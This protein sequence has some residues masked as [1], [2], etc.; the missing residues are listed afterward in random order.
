MSD[1]FYDA[2]EPGKPRL[3]D[4]ALSRKKERRRWRIELG[5]KMYPHLSN[6]QSRKLTAGLT[7]SKESAI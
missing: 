2:P 1:N 5:R 7:M 4:A 3:S 6:R